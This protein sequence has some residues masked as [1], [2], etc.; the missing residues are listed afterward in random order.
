MSDAA[1]RTVAQRTAD[2]REF[3]DSI[4]EQV[5]AERASLAGE[6]AKAGV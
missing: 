5:E 4:D 3:L 2:V 6:L 1:L